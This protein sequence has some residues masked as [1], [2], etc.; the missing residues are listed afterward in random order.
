MNLLIGRNPYP[1]LEQR[2]EELA[3]LIDG[4]A[5]RAR[6]AY[7]C[8][9]D[10]AVLPE[11]AVN[12]GL[13]GTAAQ[14][15][16]PLKGSVL[17]HM[18]EVARRHRTYVI[19]PLFLEEE[20][21]ESWSNAC[22]LVD[23]EGE[24]VGVYRKVF[25]VSAYDRPLLEGGVTPGVEFPFFDCDFGKLGMQICFDV[26][27]EVGWKA[28]AEVGAEIVAWP[29]QS[30]QTV[31]PAIY[32]RRFGYY[33]VSSTWRNNATIFEPNGMVATQIREPERL[34]VHRVDLSYAIIGWQPKLGNGAIFTNAYGD[35][36][37][38]HYS[39]EEDAGIF[40][41][42]DPDKPIGEMV[43]ELG[44]EMPEQAVARNREL[45]DVLRPAQLQQA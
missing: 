17:E 40:W 25:P 45:Q 35:R 15:S 18:G 43:A 42:N 39:E 19:V 9:L 28:L 14:V 37:G 7:D 8:G 13:E 4:M 10:L 2:L 31:Q 23:R 16:F 11:V 12:G 34:L 36:A 1:G 21:G 3:D 33:L 41:S 29:T 20:D 38:F 32:A 27:F 44:L 26:T 6:E 30:P 5:A 22:A 24:L